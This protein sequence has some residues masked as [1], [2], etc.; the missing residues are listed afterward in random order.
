MTT[1][2]DLH[3]LPWQVKYRRRF[4]TGKSHPCI[5]DATDA[6]I[7]EITCKHANETAQAIV[8]AVNTQYV[9][10]TKREAA[11]TKREFEDMLN[12]FAIRAGDDHW[13]RIYGKIVTDYGYACVGDVLPKDYDSILRELESE[14]SHGIDQ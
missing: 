14:H 10:Q 7:T 2:N 12:D 13:D 4:E 11:Q 3:P 8:N 6:L 5:I 9:A 1:L